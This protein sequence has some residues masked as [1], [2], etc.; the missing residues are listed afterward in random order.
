MESKRIKNTSQDGSKIGTGEE[1]LFQDE[2]YVAPSSDSSQTS[3]PPNNG[4]DGTQND[5]NDNEE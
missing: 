2:M 4:N 1:Q 3:S 5:S